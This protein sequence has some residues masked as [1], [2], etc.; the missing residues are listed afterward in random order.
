MFSVVYIDEG[1]YRVDTGRVTFMVDWQ[2][3]LCVCRKFNLDG[4]S[5]SHAIAAI[6]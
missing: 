3:R 6:Q 1:N 5:C 4:L 2:A